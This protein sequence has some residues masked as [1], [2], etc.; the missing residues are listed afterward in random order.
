MLAQI[1]ARNYVEIETLIPLPA[2]SIMVR[3]S[4]LSLS[5]AAAAGPDRPN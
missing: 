3:R 1:L 5:T 2:I 4:S